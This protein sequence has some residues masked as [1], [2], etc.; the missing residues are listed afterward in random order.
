MRSTKV[1][2]ASLATVALAGLTGC[3]TSPDSSLSA[4]SSAQVSA[5]H[6]AP[7]SLL[8]DSAHP[9]PPVKPAPGDSIRPPRPPKPAPGDSI[10]PPKPPKPPVDS[11]RP[12]PPVKPAPG[13]SIR[14]PRPPKP[15]LGDSTK[16]V[17]PDSLHRA[18]KPPKKK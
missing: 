9:A 3:L 8:A 15:V 14:P 12:Q 4:Q 17:K 16:P 2:L 13:D 5:A 1:L 6:Q 11:L 10:R 7:D 18:P